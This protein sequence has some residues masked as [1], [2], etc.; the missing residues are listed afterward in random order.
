MRKPFKQYDKENPEIWELFKNYAL[1][2]IK[3]GFKTFG[4]KAIF[5]V[6]RY[7]ESIKKGSDG[8]KVNNTY[9]PDYVDKFEKEFPQHIGFFRK[10]ERKVAK[11]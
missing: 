10:R 8:F 2:A 7:N 6:I 3:N 11:R 1:S 9:T 5:E 4:S